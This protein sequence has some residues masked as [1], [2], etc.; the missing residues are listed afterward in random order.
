MTR[1]I[2]LPYLL[3]LLHAACNAADP[4]L[5]AM[6]FA[7]AEQLVSSDG[8]LQMSGHVTIRAFSAA[9]MRQ[10]DLLLGDGSGRIWWLKNESSGASIRFSAP[11][12]VVAADRSQWG[13]GYTGAALHDINSDGRNDLLVAHSDNLI[14]IHLNTGSSTEPEFAAESLQVRVQQGCQGRFD[15]ADW[16]GDGL[17]D[18]ITGSFGGAVTWHRNLGTRSQPAFAESQPFHD[19]TAAYNSHPRIVDFDHDGNPDLLLGIN[20]GTVT[21]YRRSGPEQQSQLSNGRQ[22]QWSTG[23]HL[24]IRDLNSD[25]T[26]PEICDLNGDGVVDLLSGGR[27]GRLFLMRGVSA[28]DR[29]DDFRR[30][31]QTASRPLPAQIA[32][33]AELREGLFSALAA[34]QADLNAGLLPPNS[35]EQLFQQLAALAAQYPQLLQRQ[36]LDAKQYSAAVM[37]AGR[38]WTVLLESLPPDRDH[39]VRVAN[40]LDFRGG[41]RQLLIDLGLLFVDNNTATAE[42]LEAMHRLLIAM[43]GNIW[44]VRTITVAGWLGPDVS[45]YPLGA[46]SGVNIFDMPLGRPENSFPAD[47]P[48]PGI[49]DVYLICLAHEIAHNMLDTVGRELRPDLFTRKYSALAQAAGP[50]VVFHDPVTRGINRPAT[51]QKFRDAGHWDG[52]PLTWNEAWKNYFAAEERFQKGYSR[53][54]IQFFLDAPQEGFST[55]ANQYF[56]DTRLMLE[57]CA[58]RWEQGHHGNINQFLLIAEY[59]SEGRETLPMYR[60]VP[61]GALELGTAR[62]ERDQQ[63]R[64]VAIALNHLRANFTYDQSDLI[65]TLNLSER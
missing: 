50:L 10:P 38:Y 42:H 56:A 62:V 45:R 43:P 33:D 47:S 6:S 5:P 49:T 16:D 53:G 34:I 7:A 30:L 37:L 26:T 17:A 48:R 40:A 32:A 22:L 61:G 23:G 8:P 12:A 55:L 11:Q 39:W 46:S 35:R 1:L 58:A 44:K 28:M 27:N 9:P 54:N 57:F 19:I 25:D 51:Q 4:L 24:N 29:A 63:G 65:R 20:W 64:I 3:C 21:L 31:L 36:Q 41:Y 15:I 52:D 59:L 18:L 14:S 13:A 2:L 60:M